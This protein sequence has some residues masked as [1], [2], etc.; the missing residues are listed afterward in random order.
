MAVVSQ[1]MVS[2]FLY[3]S[4]IHKLA[5]RRFNCNTPQI[6]SPFVATVI[7]IIAEIL[8]SAIKK[9]LKNGGISILLEFTSI[10]QL[11]CKC[12]SVACDL[13]LQLLLSADLEGCMVL[14]YCYSMCPF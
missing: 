2:A 6:I 8:T 5:K 10:R 14:V 13:G 9:N 4:L 11:L 3:F 12:A 7:V 1:N